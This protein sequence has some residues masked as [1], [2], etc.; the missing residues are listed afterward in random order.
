MPQSA[1]PKNPQVG[2]RVREELLIEIRVLAT[3]QRRLLSEV[4]EE[5]FEDILKKYRDKRK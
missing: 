1:K 3:R 4:V 2:A 5:A